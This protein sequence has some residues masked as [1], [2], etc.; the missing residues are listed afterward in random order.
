MTRIANLERGG[1]TAGGHDGPVSCV[2]MRED[3]SLVSGG[4]DTALLLWSPAGRIEDRLTGHAALV[5]S[6]AWSPEGA[7]IASASSDHTARV[8]NAASGLCTAVLSGHADDVNSVAWS[9]DGAR[10]VTGSFD[11]TAR[12]FDAGTGALETRLAGH[13]GDVNGVAWSVDG[14]TIATASDDETARLWSWRGELLRELRGHSDWVDQVAFSPDGRL[15]ATASLDRTARIWDV[16]TGEELACLGEHGCT[17]K[18]VR[19]SPCGRYLATA[20]YDKRIRIF[21]RATWR[22]IDSLRDTRMWNR[23]LAWSWPGRIATGSFARAPV[24]WRIGETEARTADRLGT[25]GINGLALAPDGRVAALACDDGGARLVEVETGRIL[26][27]RFDHEGALLSAAW[28]RDGRRIAFGG[29]DDRVSIY[30][31]GE[32]DPAVWIGGTGDPVNAVAFSAAGETLALG[33]F[34]GMLSVWN[35]DDGAPLGRIGTHRGS[36]KSLAPVGAG[37]WI[38]GGRDG[39]L[40]I[41]GEGAARS[42]EVGPTIVNGVAVSPDGGSVACVSRA[43]GVD[44]FDLRTGERRASFR[45]HGGSARAVAFSPDGRLVVAGYYDGHLLFWEPARGRARLVRPFGATAI[46][47]VAFA[48]DA[49]AVVVATWDPCGRFGVVDCASAELRSEHA[50]AGRWS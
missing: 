35:A 25:P 29:W 6:V 48:G 33:S 12:V 41:H 32:R 9:P 15:L 30:R 17:V 16:A 43:R 47:A 21:E 18:A 11:G 34:M 36:I 24:R 14:S 19:W 3:G 38:S 20:A 26:R 8:W 28:S 23:T 44:V 5:N 46:S 7:R 4:Y 39:R 31:D 10:V 50:V 13:R 22:V 40:R 49:G 45:E 1:R 27:E 42:I 2:D 37:L